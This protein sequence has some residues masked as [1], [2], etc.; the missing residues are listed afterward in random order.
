MYALKKVIII[1]SSS[2]VKNPKSIIK[3]ADSI[4]KKHYS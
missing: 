1:K 2:T 4:Q 3:Y